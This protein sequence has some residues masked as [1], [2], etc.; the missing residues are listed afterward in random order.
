MEG[1]TYPKINRIKKK[2]LDKIKIDPEKVKEYRYVD[3]L[4]EL[5][6]GGYVRWVNVEDTSKLMAGGFVVRVDIE[7][8]GT[9]IVCKNRG[10]IFQFWMDEC[11][12]FQKISD[13]EHIIL[14][15]NT[16]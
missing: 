1:L 3:E 7:E 14:L 16:L 15:A 12:V 8:E 5:K 11:I 4:H 2:V 13:Q 10:K 6:T 9:R